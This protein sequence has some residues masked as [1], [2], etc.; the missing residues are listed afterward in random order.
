MHDSF[1]NISLCDIDIEL[2][3]LP[4]WS[5]RAVSYD[6]ISPWCHFLLKSAKCTGPSGIISAFKGIVLFLDQITFEMLQIV[7]LF[8]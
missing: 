6:L 4:S 2:F 5:S 1:A 3:S 7:D 8:L